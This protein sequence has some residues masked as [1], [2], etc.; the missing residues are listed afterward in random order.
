MRSFLFLFIFLI[1]FIGCFST[2][3]GSSSNRALSNNTPR[4]TGIINDTALN[5]AIVESYHYLKSRVRNDA[6]IGIANFYSPTKQ[7]SDYFVDGLSKQIVDD[8]IFRLVDIGNLKIIDQEMSRQLSGTVSDETAKRL[9]QQYGT[10]YIIIGN[11]DQLGQTRDYRIKITITNVETTQIQGIFYADIRSNAELAQYLPENNLNRNTQQ[12]NAT[13]P[14]QRI[15]F[16]RNITKQQYNELFRTFKLE[17]EARSGEFTDA[18]LINGGTS[19]PYISY[20][21]G[22]GE[23]DFTIKVAG[24]YYT[25]MYTYG[26]FGKNERS[27]MQRFNIERE[28]L[29]EKYGNPDISMFFRQ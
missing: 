2:P 26:P 21:K 8:S 18:Y 9:G 7:L 25:E 15:Y 27:I 24:P 20:S 3:E 13:N 29:N 5:N 1:L 6:V 22:R 14:N 10:D 16:F 17:I 23:W 12:Q 4:F 28:I 19:D 11:I